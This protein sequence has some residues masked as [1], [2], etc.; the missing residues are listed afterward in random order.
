MAVRHDR[1]A[2]TAP[3]ELST[4]A[5]P[6]QGAASARHASKLP[7]NMAA[8]IIALGTADGFPARLVHALA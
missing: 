5:A 6:T 3:R 8:M 4:E 7:Q 2:C 1:G